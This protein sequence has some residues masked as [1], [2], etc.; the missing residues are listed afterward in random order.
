MIPWESLPDFARG[1]TVVAE[2]HDRGV[3]FLTGGGSMS[4]GGDPP[5]GRYLE[6]AAHAGCWDARR[7][8]LWLPDLPESTVLWDVKLLVG[9]RGRDVL[10]AARDARLE[11]A[12]KLESLERQ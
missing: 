7:V 11:V 8:L 5:D 4:S 2:P 1:Q 10:P 3:F 6:V 12:G 9:G